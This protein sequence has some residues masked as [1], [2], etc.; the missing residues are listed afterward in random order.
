MRSIGESLVNYGGICESYDSD[1]E[2]YTYEDMN[3]EI[4]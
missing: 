3:I 4:N 2:T 1:L